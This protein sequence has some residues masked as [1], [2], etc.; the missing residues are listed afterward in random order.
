MRKSFILRCKKI[1]LRE[2]ARLA[3]ELEP[4]IAA[5]AKEKEYDRKT[6]LKKSSKSGSP[7]HTRTE[8]AKIAGM[9]E[10]TIAKVKVIEEQVSGEV[11]EHVTAL[12]L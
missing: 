6:T 9:S 2:R 1:K 12:S 8:V 11:K 10:D 7:I 4:L 3:L 5:K